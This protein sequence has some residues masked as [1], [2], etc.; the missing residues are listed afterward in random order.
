MHAC[1]LV[2]TSLK[3]GLLEQQAEGSSG[4]HPQ[5]CSLLGMLQGPTSSGKT[6]LVGYLA[7]QT[8]HHLT[9]INNHEGTDLQEYL[10]S[11]VPDAQGRLAFQEGP[12]VKALREG[13]WVV[14]DELN[15][16][17]SDVLEALNRC[18]PLSSSLVL[19]DQDS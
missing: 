18:E 7:A 15:L 2:L 16:A 17:P 10:G 6:S 3:M 13:H 4:C 11:S 14:L 8:G 9:R 5:S 19:F 1:I 12:L